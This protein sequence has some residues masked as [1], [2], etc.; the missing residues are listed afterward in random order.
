MLIWLIFVVK[1]VTSLV[2][3][4]V[5]YKITKPHTS[6]RRVVK[7]R[8]KGY[9]LIWTA[10]LWAVGCMLIPVVTAIPSLIQFEVL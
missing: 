2:A 6:I 4:F 8:D 7:G 1:L 9:F 5:L 3:S 10:Y